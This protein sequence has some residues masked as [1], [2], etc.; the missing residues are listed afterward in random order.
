M[1]NRLLVANRGEIAR[2]VFHTC[3]ELGVETVAV[4]SDPD[5]AAPHVTEADVAV[6]L[7]GAALRE[8]YLRG[9][10]LAEA[11]RAAG[12]DAVHPGYGFL[13]ENAE[14]AQTVLDAGLTWVGP[15]PKAI[16]SMGSK[17]EAKRL[18][19]DA[20]VPVLSSLDPASVTEADLPVLIKAS[21]GGGG[22][23]M[24]V[25]RSLSELPGQVEAARAEAASAFGDDTVFC[26][27]YL[28]A[29]RHIEVQV[30]ADEHGTVWTLPERECSIQRRHQKVIEESP[31]PLVER[32]NGMRE[33]LCDAARAAAEAIGY[34]GA[35]TVEF[36][37]ESVGGSAGGEAPRVRFFFLEMN[38]RLQVEH[39]VTECVTGVDLVA[40][41]LRIAEGAP[42][43]P[44]PPAPSGH[45]IEARLYAETVTV[46][47]G[48][49]RWAPQVGTLERFAVPGVSVE[50]GIPAA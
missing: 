12:A 32:V 45:A 3:R 44:H 38:T 28:P 21:A 50:F 10:L 7:P 31:S 49:A 16:E 29:G 35:G 36:L 26:E 41:Q 14:F 19:A 23:G 46:E 22:R 25:A 13:S 6:R 40:W 34:L 30:L 18:L 37:A 8:T 4:C 2:R 39:P 24:R 11:A 27:S 1:I 42:L 17:L 33:Q 9:D 48:Q 20:G 43:P 5:A 15:P 47:A